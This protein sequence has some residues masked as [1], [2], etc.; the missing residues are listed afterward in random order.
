MSVALRPVPLG[1]QVGA[2]GRDE[3]AREAPRAWLTARTLSRAS[4]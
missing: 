3:S 1:F 4:L 2:R